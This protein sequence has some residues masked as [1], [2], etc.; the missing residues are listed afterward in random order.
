[1]HEGKEVIVQKIVFVHMLDNSGP[2]VR[3]VT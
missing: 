3:K 2:V 1:M